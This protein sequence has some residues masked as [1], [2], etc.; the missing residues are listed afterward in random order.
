M[1]ERNSKINYVI[2]IIISGIRIQE[3]YLIPLRSRV[4]LI[5]FTEFYVKHPSLIIME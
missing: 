1:T 3:I 4:A 5:L 2:S